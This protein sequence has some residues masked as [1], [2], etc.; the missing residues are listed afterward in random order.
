MPAYIG[1]C[2]V[3]GALNIEQLP[4]SSHRK[5]KGVGRLAIFEEA[6]ALSGK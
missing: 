1:Y 2:P 4:Q 5:E 6:L 3:H